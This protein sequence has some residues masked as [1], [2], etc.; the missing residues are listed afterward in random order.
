[1][2]EARVRLTDFIQAQEHARRHESDARKGCETTG[3]NKLD[4][5]C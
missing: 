1:M 2:N 5:I 4:C 3:K